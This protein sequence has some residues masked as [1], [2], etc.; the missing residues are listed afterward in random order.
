MEIKNNYEGAYLR[1]D[2]SF[3]KSF[4][5]DL[6]DFSIY[7]AM[8]TQLQK[9]SNISNIDYATLRLITTIQS[10]RCP[11]APAR[12]CFC[13][14]FINHTNLVFQPMVFSCELLAAQELW[15]ILCWT[16]IVNKLGSRGRPR[17]GDH[18][19]QVPS[20]GPLA[21]AC[22]T[23]GPSPYCWSYFSPRWLS[24]PGTLIASK[25]RR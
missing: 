11:A 5:L 1:L 24:S 7:N 21:V 2:D 25:R 16:L 15:D 6:L 10:K 19:A 9:N 23:N 4:H 17:P 22:C 20:T 3:L 14:S 8:A 13:T 18:K 12:A